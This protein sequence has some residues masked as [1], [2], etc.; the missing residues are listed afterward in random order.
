MKPQLFGI[1][2]LL[3]LSLSASAQGGKYGA[4]PE[5]S[6]Q[7][8]ESLSL[9][10]EFVKQKNYVDALPGWK[11]ACTV[12]PQS[13]KSLYINGVKMYRAFIKAEKD[14]ARR[15]ELVDTLY[16]I[17][18][19]RIANFGQEGYVKGRKA[20]E[21]MRYGKD[22]PAAA[23]ALFKESMDLM[24]GKSE[25]G[26]IAGYYQSLYQ[27]YKKKEIEKAA[28]LEAY[29]P[30]SDI[31]VE[32]YKVAEAK[33]DPV[34]AKEAVDKAKNNVDEIFIKVGAC[35]DIVSVFQTKVTSEPDN[36]EL[37]KRSLRI[38]TNRDCIDNDFYLDLA[39][40]VHEAEPSASSAY[41]IGKKEFASK[42]YGSAMG[43]FEQALE[44]ATSDD[45]DRESYALSCAQTSMKR[46]SVQSAYNYADKALSYNSNSGQAYLI[47]AQAVAGSKCGTNGQEVRYVYW[48]AYDLAAKAKSVDSSVSASA[49]RLMSAYK[50]NWPSKKDL[51]EWSMLDTK[52]VK[53]G[54]WVNQSTAVREGEG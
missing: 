43:Y 35:E 42:S 14:E 34:K 44:L 50:N 52:E 41:A 2:A 16:Q 53:V 4:T 30:V 25:A 20:S 48:L 49:N 36:L 17:Y 31:I 1:V 40:A 46:G 3:F 23:N 10:G 5:D 33:K 45:P 7:C 47:K 18:D 11:T 24:K 28:L 8:I 39:K 29:L 9:Y 22:N 54:C 15:A 51:F 37:K 21:M 32:A 6:V 26:V 12:C 27:M 19:W 38:M 13:R